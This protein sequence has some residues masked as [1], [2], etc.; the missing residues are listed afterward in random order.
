MD[1]RLTPE[2]QNAV[3]EDALHTYPLASMPRDITATVMARIQAVPAPRPFRFTRNDFVIALV[4]SL[5]TAAIWF[6]I[7]NFPPLLLAQLRVQG[8]LFYQDLIV[9]ARWLVPAIAFGLSAL[10]AAMTI[11]YLKQQL[12]K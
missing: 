9:N 4:L 6:S 11:P 5:S 7:Q 2:Q 8:I 1:N 10:L 12:M 3:I